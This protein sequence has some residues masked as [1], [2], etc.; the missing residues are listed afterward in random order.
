MTCSSPWP[1]VKWAGCSESIS[2]RSLIA[3]RP[4]WYRPIP[5]GR[6]LRVA[7]E[8]MTYI[9]DHCRPPTLRA[10]M[11][12]FIGSG[13]AARHAFERMDADIRLRTW[14]SEAAFTASGTCASAD[15]FVKI[16]EE[17]F[18]EAGSPE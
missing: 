8:V 4:S 13:G 5:G 2:V 3:R 15:E 11:V 12:P 16:L 6:T 17:L 9:A 18:A 10:A 14:M 1:A 7:I